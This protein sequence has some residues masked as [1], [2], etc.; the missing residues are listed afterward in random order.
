M[1]SSSQDKTFEAAKRD[2][3][4]KVLQ[5]WLLLTTVPVLTTVALA[6]VLPF[7]REAYPDA[8]PW[9]GTDT[10][11]ASGLYLIIVL[12][13]WHVISQQRRITKLRDALY[14][15]R[16][17]AQDHRQRHRNR[18]M[19]ICALNQAVGDENDPRAVFETLTKLCKDVFVSDQASL[20][21]FD[22]KTQ[23]LVVESAIG[24][25]DTAR[26]LGARRN[27][28]EGIAGWVAERREPLLV[29]KHFD[30]SQFR[31]R[32]PDPGAIRSAMVVP[33]VVREQLVGVLSV[34][35]VRS[36]V[37]YDED[38]LTT[39]QVFAETAEFC[40]RHAENADWM[41]GLI[42]QLHDMRQREAQS[43]KDSSAGSQRAKG[44]PSPDTI[45][46]PS[47]DSG[48]YDQ[49]R[50]TRVTTIRGDGMNY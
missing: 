26:V 46:I 32:L 20:M 41:R 14:E 3:D 16:S 23:S 2:L 49:V 13:A 45:E 42:H 30:L 28:G 22:Y 43:A 8:W 31:G 47:L 24:H 33:L 12:F 35:N 9:A 29:S 34:A 40:I 10:L 7:V 21:T 38:D 4:S 19:A 50:S 6:T 48:E 15:A 18:I 5:Q 36:N 37:D 25:E 11:L 27:L 44:G 17:N 1:E 39:L